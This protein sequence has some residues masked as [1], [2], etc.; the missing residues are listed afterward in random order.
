MKRSNPEALPK[1]VAVYLRVSSEEQVAGYSLPA[2]ERAAETHC[3]S[4]GWTIVA[5]YRDEGV[6][7]R[8]DDERKR[9]EFA[10]LMADAEARRFD[11]VVVHKLDRFAR[12]RRLAF[13]AL[14]RLGKNGIGFVSLMENMDYS[15]PAG[16]LMLTMLVGMA[17]FYSDNLSGE[18][19][20]GKHERKLQGRHNGLLPFGVTVD[21]RGVPI[22]ATDPVYCSVATRESIAPAHGLIRAFELAASGFTDREIADALNRDGYLTSGNRGQNRLTKDSVRVILLN[23]FYRG[24]LPDGEGGWVAGK[25]GTLIDPVLFD[26][27]TAARSLNTS[28]PR[29]VSTLRKPWA[30]SG[31]AYCGECGKPLNAHTGG[32]GRRRVRCAGRTQNHDCQEPS[33]YADAIE[34]QIATLLASFEIPESEHGNLLAAWRAFAQPRKSDLRD[35]YKLQQ[36]LG[37]IRELYLEGDLTKFEYQ[38]QRDRV[39]SEL[40]AIPDGLDTTDEAGRR[41]ASYLSDVSIAWK[42]ATPEERNK[43]ARQL[44]SK[45]IVL[46]RAAVAIVP[47]LDFRPFFKIVA[48]NDSEEVCYGGS[49]GIRTRDL[50]LDRAAC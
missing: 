24:D 20:K 13:D 9:P 49:D 4:N 1:R 30:L 47:R 5:T 41:L 18:T 2:Q 32:T 50:S 7:A 43:L 10:R 11:V 14:H 27:A 34:D 16:Q 33:F 17:Q 25:H 37:R 8:T 48:V 35:R 36:R 38:D 23:R 26:R 22:L 46:N 31:V 15:T 29:R 21:D 19:K 28:K 39:E 42:V 3:A 44:F 12:N 45:V 6:S 40:A